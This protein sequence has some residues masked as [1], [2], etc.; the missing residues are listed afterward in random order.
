MMHILFVGSFLVSY[1]LTNFVKEIIAG[2][3][4]GA[5]IFFIILAGSLV[6]AY[7]I[8]RKYMLSQKQNKVGEDSR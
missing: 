7:C 8:R 5:V 3:P 6:G 1:L 2:S 4:C